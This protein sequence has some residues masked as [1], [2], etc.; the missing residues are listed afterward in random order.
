MKYVKKL[1][2][3]TTC[4]L[5]GCSDDPTE[6]SKQNELVGSI[7][8]PANT[9]AALVGIASDG[10]IIKIYTGTGREYVSWSDD[11]TKIIFVNHES[12]LATKIP[13][14][15]EAKGNVRATLVETADANGNIREH[16]TV[17]PI[18]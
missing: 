5:V 10:E 15:V 2:L 3:V 17:I 4:V 13:F 6:P 14:R 18:N 8:I 16:N 7:T 11:N 1:A 12:P 9:H